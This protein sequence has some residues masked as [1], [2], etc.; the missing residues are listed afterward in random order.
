MAT[1][2]AYCYFFV[3]FGFISIAIDS[4]WIG[5]AFERKEPEGE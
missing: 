3:G 4:S 1:P 2:S 5:L